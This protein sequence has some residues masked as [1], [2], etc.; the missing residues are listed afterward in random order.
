MRI[1]S[2]QSPMTVWSEGQEEN[3]GDLLGNEISAFQIK[4]SL[5]WANTDVFKPFSRCARGSTSKNTGPYILDVFDKWKKFL[6][7]L[8][9]FC[10][11]SSVLITFYSIRHESTSLAS[12]VGM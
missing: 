8:E 3:P 6:W 4:H 9:V 5:N 2:L 1:N 7:E 11:A 12:V 10:G